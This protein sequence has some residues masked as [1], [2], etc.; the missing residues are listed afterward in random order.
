MKFINKNKIVVALLLTVLWSCDSNKKAEKEVSSKEGKVVNVPNFNADSAYNFVEKQVAFGP[1][2]PG[3]EAHKEAAV[4]FIEKFESYGAKVQ[5]Q[6][7]EVTTF[8]NQTVPL[9]NIIASFNPEKKKRV[10]LAAHWD[11]RPFADKDTERQFEPIDAA[12]DGASGVGVLLELARVIGNNTPPEI[13]IDMILFDGEDWGNDTSTQDPVELRDGWDSWWCLGSQ[14]WSK[15]KHEAGYSAYYGILLD[16]VGA[17]GSQFHM[18]GGSMYYAPGVMQKVWNRAHKLGFG[19]YFVKNT[20]DGITDD[21]VFVN[22][23]A[24]IPMIDIVH[25][26]P[27]HGYFGDYHHTHKD[28]IGIISEETLEAV[29]ETVL[30][31]LYHE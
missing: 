31:V 24:K 5:T 15:N 28:N 19:R 25:Y 23:Y 2:V 10:L 12:N 16:M 4:Y 21:H 7:F 8:D 26:D 1:R 9:R 22:E 29:G 11:S 14:Y 13:G 20:I 17:K 27:E 18:E 3:S 6:D 30:H